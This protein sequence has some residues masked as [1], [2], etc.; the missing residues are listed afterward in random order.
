[1][2]Q[3]QLQLERSAYAPGETVRAW[4]RAVEGGD[5]RAGMAQV[6]YVERSEDYTEVAWEKMERLW[7]GD[8]TQG[9]SF[10]FEIQLPADAKPGYC[11]E[12]GSLAWE[13]LARSDEFGRDTTVAEPF[14]L[15]PPDGGYDLPVAA[16]ASGPT[17]VWVRS[18]VL[19]GPAIGAGV[20]YSI[21]R[22]PGAVG[23][24]ALVGGSSAFEWRRRAKHFEVELP[25]PVRRGE[26]AR[27]SVR[28]ID[29]AD[30]E[31]E[32]QAELECIERYAYRSHS[33]RGGAHRETKEET[34][35]VERVPLA[36]AQRAVDIVVPAAMPFTHEGSAVA[37][38]WK[39]IVREHRDNAM[40]RL[41][42]QPLL[43]LP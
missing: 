13:V 27:I 25:R 23:G 39:V 2:P 43:V 12:N 17:P 33:G 10:E 14:E 42:E 37:Y 11:S 41:A 3:I 36:T 6:R 22:V 9:A 19:A 24:A 4:A 8:L 32:L 28:L 20:G 15:T 5:S 16:P 29:A 38:L 7:H 18:L 40:D 35:H 1:M 26:A 31:G 30:V 34:L 21:A